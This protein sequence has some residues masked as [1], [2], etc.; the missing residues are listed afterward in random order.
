MNNKLLKSTFILLVGGFV[1]KVLGMVIK[2]TMG[3]MLG[4]EV[5][6]YI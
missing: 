2:M 4:V 3:R 1:T 5:L 6:G